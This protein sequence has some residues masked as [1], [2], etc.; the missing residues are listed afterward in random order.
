VGRVIGPEHHVARA[1]LYQLGELHLAAGRFAEAYALY[2]EIRRLSAAEEGE[3]S[4]GVLSSLAMMAETR[5]R[6][7]ELAEA[8]AAFREVIV[9]RGRYTGAGHPF[10]LLTRLQR[11]QAVLLPQ[12]RFAEAAD[13]LRQIRAVA[14][15]G[16][17]AQRVPVAEALAAALAAWPAHGGGPEYEAFRREMRADGERP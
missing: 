15:A 17:P 11:V 14:Q 9:L 1:A 13:E 6:Q 12:R 5:A 7:G 8:D 2:A 10:T 3:A 4:H 16:P